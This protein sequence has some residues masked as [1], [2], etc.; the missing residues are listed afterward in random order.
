MSPDPPKITTMRLTA[1]TSTSLSL[2]W[3][4]SP[5]HRAQD[6]PIR[7]ELTYRKKVHTP[8][9]PPLQFVLSLYP[10]IVMCGHI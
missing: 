5:R 10:S 8:G 7:Y 1:R 4:V 2:S 3:E 6:R 9:S